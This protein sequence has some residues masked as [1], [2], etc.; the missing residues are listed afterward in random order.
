MD[1]GKGKLHSQLGFGDPEPHSVQQLKLQSQRHIKL[2]CLFKT[3]DTLMASQDVKRVP[4][5]A[6]APCMHCSSES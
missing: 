1:S 3:K 2:S 5:F 6:E 4:C